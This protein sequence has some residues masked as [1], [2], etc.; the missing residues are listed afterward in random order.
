VH[1]RT[2]VVPVCVYSESEILTPLTYSVIY[3]SMTKNFKAILYT[4][5]LRSNLLQTTKFHSIVPY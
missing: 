1:A 2:G 4:H 3:F 5:I